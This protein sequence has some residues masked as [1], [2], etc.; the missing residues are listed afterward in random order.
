MLYAVFGAVLVIFVIDVINVTVTLDQ[1]PTLGIWVSSGV[2][3]WLNKEVA[4]R[5][6]TIMG[7]QVTRHADIDSEKGKDLSHT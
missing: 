2:G 4:W 6:D 7:M 1:K 5:R 3:G